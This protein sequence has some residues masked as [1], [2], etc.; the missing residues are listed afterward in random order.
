MEIWEK[1][2]YHYIDKNKS[3][4]GKEGSPTKV[5]YMN[6]TQNNPSKALI[7]TAG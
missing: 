5:N 1:G 4:H 2:G 7:N 3:G 6:S